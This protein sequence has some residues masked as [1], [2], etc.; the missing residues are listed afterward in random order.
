LGLHNFTLLRS[1]WTLH[2]TSLLRTFF[3]PWITRFFFVLSY[4]S[5]RNFNM[6][7]WLNSPLIRQD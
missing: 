5:V 6:L 1:F 3:P 7:P 4:H 2:R